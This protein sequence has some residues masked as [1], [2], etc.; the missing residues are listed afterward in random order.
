MTDYFSQIFDEVD[1]DDALELETQKSY[2]QR[3]FGT[4]APE[5]E[6]EYKPIA[7]QEMLSG[8]FSEEYLS[9]LPEPAPFDVS[10]LPGGYDFVTPMEAFRAVLGP[11]VAP[12]VWSNQL[13]A[14]YERNI[15]GL[16]GERPTQLYLPEFSNYEQAANSEYVNPEDPSLSMEYK[17]RIFAGQFGSPLR[18]IEEA[19]RGPETDENQ[20]F[21]SGR[22]TVPDTPEQSADYL[23]AA[24]RGMQ[25]AASTFGIG[26]PAGDMVARG[27]GHAAS[28]LAP[29]G[30]ALYNEQAISEMMSDPLLMVDFYLGSQFAKGLRLGNRFLINRSPVYA[31][32]ARGINAVLVSPIA[33]SANRLASKASREVYRFTRPFTGESA[34][35]VERAAQ[36][37]GV[38]EEKLRR[39]V[40]G[41]WETPFFGEEIAPRF[42]SMT[43]K[44]PADLQ[45]IYGR[46]GRV[47]RVTLEESLVAEDLMGEYVRN[48]FPDL[49]VDAQNQIGQRIRFNL[50][51]SARLPETDRLMGI[52]T[53]DIIGDKGYM[54]HL[55][56]P[57]ANRARGLSAT[58]A[59]RLAQRSENILGRE[60]TQTLHRR[61]LR[62]TIMDYNEMAASG[63][64]G[65]MDGQLTVLGTDEVIKKWGKD[66]V[67]EGFHRV[68]KLFNDNDR[69]LTL[70]RFSRSVQA[71]S[72]AGFLRE[73]SINPA[74]L[75]DAGPT[76]A[77]KLGAAEF[78]RTF[79]RLGEDLSNIA[80]NVKWKDPETLS[81][82]VHY[83][84]VFM[85]LQ[86]RPEPYLR[87]M[88]RVVALWKGLTLTPFM[89]YH[90]RNAV[91][92]MNNAFMSGK[93]DIF[94]AI[95][96]IFPS[97]RAEWSLEFERLGLH[98]RG[99]VSQAWASSADTGYIRSFD[100]TQ[101]E[102]GWNRLNPL[103]NDF[104][105]KTVAEAIENH[106][107]RTSFFGARRRA[108]SIREAEGMVY[109]Y[110]FDYA[111]VPQWFQIGTP[112]RRTSAFPIWTMKN[113]PVQLE[114]LFTT[115]AHFGFKGRY[116]NLSE[117]AA[118][119]DWRDMPEFVR[120]GAGFAVPG[121]DPNRPLFFRP[122]NFD[123]AASLS[124][125]SDPRRFVWELFNPF[126]TVPIEQLTPTVSTGGEAGTMTAAPLGPL[127]NPDKVPQARATGYQQFFGRPIYR[128]WVD[129]N[130]AMPIVGDTHMPWW[131]QR[132]DHAARSFLRFYSEASTAIREG[133]RMA[134]GTSAYD[135]GEYGAR[136]F[137]GLPLFAANRDQVIY[138]ALKDNDRNLE[139]LWQEA[140]DANER[141]E[142][143]HASTL[144]DLKWSYLQRIA[145]LSHGTFMEV[146]P[147]DGTPRPWGDIARDGEHA[148]QGR[149]DNYRDLLQTF[150]LLFYGRVSWEAAAGYKHDPIPLDQSEMDFLVEMFDAN[151]N[152]Y[153]TVVAGLAE[154]GEE[155]NLGGEQGYADKF[156][157]GRPE[158]HT[159]WYEDIMKRYETEE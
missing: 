93:A 89:P 95:D 128:P 157:E 152:S 137:F 151:I 124:E 109:K 42:T 13:Q 147:W 16:R 94:D 46:M 53:Q 118:Y 41:S 79:G 40:G 120:E 102:S 73:A 65:F 117:Q 34:W 136:R 19:I 105:G 148:I 27:L 146:N 10:Q 104:I 45:D 75:S 32:T 23:R 29:L 4:S 37:A 84:Q 38:A 131:A 96:A 81:A 68:N 12:M 85:D 28:E 15:Q 30:A 110:H 88:D 80:S 2:Y 153:I 14:A 139:A 8:A 39:T 130:P 21:T 70:G 91:G 24:G 90:V 66:V 52:P 127:V 156:G 159:E 55:F 111:D 119:A 64:V 132:I 76:I 78:Q 17:S 43:E 33:E 5:P 125:V 61:R 101:M 56:T 158:D 63:R 100:G 18:G 134:E 48:A 133:Q 11:A 36:Q 57:E 149:R 138:Y 31:E 62:G 25:H 22:A 1:E 3:L 74:F 69:V 58:W 103:H 98:R 59:R 154:L 44:A 83:T 67:P 49:P 141:K 114:H 54:L 106:Q 26:Q 126:I 35:Q 87:M 50:E 71:H 97:R 123:P 145:Y 112:L 116:M 86:K 108:M 150:N 92:G 122:E 142:P 72:A 155:M 60:L 113:I 135:P 7:F 115:P 82:V 129:W 140:R 107:R 9:Q 77:D 51:Q 121:M 20:F 6:D 99:Q 143:T 47:E 144:D